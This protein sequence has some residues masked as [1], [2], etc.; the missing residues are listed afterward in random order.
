VV[1]ALMKFNYECLKYHEWLLQ[2]KWHVLYAMVI[3]GVKDIHE[4]DW[5]CTKPINCK[6]GQCY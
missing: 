2:W 5:L 6:F 4:N 1:H 3:K